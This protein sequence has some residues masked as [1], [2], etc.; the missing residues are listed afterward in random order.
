MDMIK[1]TL[2][3]PDII[4]EDIDANLARYSTIIEGFQEAT[5]VV[6]L[7]ELF[8]TGFSMRS[9]ELAEPMEGKTMEWMA[10]Q[11][12]KFKFALAGSIIINDE[13]NFY[14]RLIWMQ[15]DGSYHYYD[16]R[17]LFRMGG[18]DEHYSPGNKPLLVEVNGAR[19]RLL[20]CYDLRFPVWSR[21]RNDYDILVYLANWPSPRRDVW[22]TLL[23]ARALENQSYTIGV[24]RVGKDAMGIDYNGES[25]VYDA[26]GNRIAYME[27]GFTGSHTIQLSLEQLS[28]FRKKFPV[29]R[30]AD[31]FMLGD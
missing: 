24:N 27:P 22:N 18:E 25:M 14:N 29:W 6:L 23:K 4:W 2:I 17:H 1:I 11:A 16:K 13:G 19:F 26:R 20:V 31:P 21:N 5:E 12:D 3:Q 9:R 28:A 10:D 7:P 8:S 30:D 15:K